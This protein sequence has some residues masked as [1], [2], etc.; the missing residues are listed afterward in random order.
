MKDFV[1][2]LLKSRSENLWFTFTMDVVAIVVGFNQSELQ[3]HLNTVDAVEKKVTILTQI[4]HEEH[5]KVKLNHAK[6]A[7][8]S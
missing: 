5:K 7:R 1:H 3:F 2:P 4:K 6:L 8:M